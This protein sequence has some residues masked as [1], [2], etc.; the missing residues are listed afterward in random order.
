VVGDDREEIVEQLG[1]FRRFG[2]G[3]VGDR[4]GSVRLCFRIEFL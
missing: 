4:R 1:R 3:V 2:D